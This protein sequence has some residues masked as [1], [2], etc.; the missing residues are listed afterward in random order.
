[1]LVAVAHAH[2]HLVIHRDIKPA[3]ILVNTD[4]QFKLLDFG[5]AKLL[6][7]DTQGAEQ[8]ALTR[9]AGR[10]MTREYAA[11][12][13]VLGQAITTATGVRCA[14]CRRAPGGRCHSAGHHTVVGRGH[15]APSLAFH[16]ADALATPG[17]LRARLRAAR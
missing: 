4:G 2:S 12:E 5:I 1:M 15:A 11:P 7:S 13:Q 6:E 9:D 3:K 10:A 16:P 17:A 8:T 14:D